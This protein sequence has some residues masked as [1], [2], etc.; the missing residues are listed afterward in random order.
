[1]LNYRNATELDL[2]KIVEIYNTTI[3][4]RMVTADVIEVSVD[5]KRDWFLQHNPKNRPLW[6]V[7]NPKREIVGWVSFQS[8]YGRPAYDGTVEM[9]IYLDLNFRGCGFGKQILE[10]SL[11]KGV[12]LDFK[13]VL[14]FIFSHNEPSVNLFQSF[15]FEIWGNL[16]NIA[17]LDGQE[18]TLLILGKRLED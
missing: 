16:P 18:K 9:S 3:A 7:E 10:Y 5:D 12:D 15:G 6:M 11:K 14:A 1:M 4:S 17:I 8:F 13:N 2:P